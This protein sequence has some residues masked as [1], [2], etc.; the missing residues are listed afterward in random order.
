MTGEH[1]HALQ[2][3]AAEL[4]APA[5]GH[6]LRVGIDGVCGSGKSTFARSLVC[7]IQDHGRPV[8][9]IDSDGFHHVKARRHQKLGAESARGY[10]E[11]AYDFASLAAKVLL[12]LGPGGD[13]RY[14]TKIHDLETDAVI[15]DETAVA[16]IDSV[17]VFDATFIQRPE[18]DGL[19]DQVVFL[20]AD[21]PSAISRG[22]ARDAERFGGEDAARRAFEARY[23]AA[24][25]I[26]LNERDPATRASILVD[27]TNVAAP[28]LVRME[29]LSER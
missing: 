11:D 19:W 4:A 2:L 15:T 26:Y 6:P 18:L 5:S 22:V 25:R 12:P 17:M 20:H 21:E 16:P 23:M 8:V 27:N 1:N 24:C 10:Y 29:R 14:A 7:A 9:F 28:T 3:V 13:L